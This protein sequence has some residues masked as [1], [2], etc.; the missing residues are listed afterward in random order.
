M[1]LQIG[2][3]LETCLYVDDL[4]AA[5]RFYCDVLGMEFISRQ[6]GRHVFLRCGQ[7]MVLLFDPRQS[8][9]PSSTLPTHGT[10]GP[11][12]IAFAA[13]E[14]QMADWKRQLEVQG[15]SIEK[16]MT[17]PGGA[18]SFYFRDPAGNSLEIASPRIW[19]LAESRSSEPRP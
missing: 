13:D 17:W 19:G 3:V 14:D 18:T 6:E 15:V 1:A 8:A 10:Q 7:Q 2:R 11:G 16:I 9:D 5:E 4:E 12:H